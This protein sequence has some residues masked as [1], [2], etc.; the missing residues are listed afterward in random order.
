MAF[1]IGKYAPYGSQTNYGI[2][3]S[4]PLAIPNCGLWFDFNDISTLFQDT[5]RTTPVTTNGQNIAGITDKSGSGNHVT[6]ASTLKPTYNTGGVL[7][8]C[9][10]FPTGN[11]SL[12]TS[13]VPATGNNSR[14]ICFLV[15]NIAN[16]GGT[17]A[18]F[19]GYGTN[20]S[21]Q[22]Y[23]LRRAG[24]DTKWNMAFNGTTQIGNV[25]GNIK[26]NVIITRY[27][28]VE[29]QLY[30]NGYQHVSTNVSL[31]TGS[32]NGITIGTLVNTP[33]A[34][35]CNEVVVY[36]RWLQDHELNL[37]TTYTMRK[38]NI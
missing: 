8:K 17:D 38:W 24:F 5:A 1:R 14:T 36:S 7:G 23:S 34:F 22:L 4:T 37:L 33:I 15:T 26:N 2:E 16:G 27:N 13:Y 29:N 35:Q 6:T 31:N 18:D 3:I 19:I 28:G 9:I 30:I 12:A 21:G 25:H 20:S 11:Y 32:G 10:S